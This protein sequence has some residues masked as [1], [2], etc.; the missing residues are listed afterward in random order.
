MRRARGRARAARRSSIA[1]LRDWRCSNRST[2]AIPLCSRRSPRILPAAKRRTA[3]RSRSGAMPNSR[4]TAIAA[5]RFI[6]PCRPVESGLEIHAHRP[7]TR[8]VGAESPPPRRAHRR[9]S[10]KPNVTERP[11]W[12]SRKRS[13]RA[14][15]AFSTATPSRGS[16]SINSRL[17]AATPSMESKNSTCAYPTLVTTPISGLGDGRQLANFPRVIHAHFQHA[18]PAAVRQAQNRKRH[19]HV[20]VKIAHGLACRQFHFQHMGNGVLGGGLARAA[21]HSHHRSAPLRGAPMRPDPAARAAHRRT[22]N[23]RFRASRNRS[24]TT[25]AA[26][27][28]QELATIVVAVMV[29]AAE[30]EIDVARVLCPRVHT[31]TGHNRGN[32]ARGLDRPRNLL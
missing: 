16:A 30:G 31:P 17:A 14:S 13:T 12:T 6:T 28:L 26:P 3:S 4:A 5:S 23:S 24:T 19:T 11:G 7:E 15:S 32:L 20:V 9:P 10:E 25:A 2:P 22:T 27:F 8:P 21:G 18:G 1:W 29:G